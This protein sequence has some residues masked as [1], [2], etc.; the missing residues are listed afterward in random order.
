MSKMVPKVRS[1]N[2]KRGTR[3]GNYRILE[4]IG[5]GCEGEVYKVTEVTTGVI[6]A[7]KLF[8]SVELESVRQLLH[9]A[10]Y[11]DQLHHTGH[12]PNYYQYGQ[13]FLDGSVGCWFLIL[14]F[15]EGIPLSKKVQ[16][17]TND[18]KEK[19]FFRLAHAVADIHE[20]GY[21]IGDFSHLGNVIQA[22]GGHIFFHRLR[23]R[24]TWSSESRL[25]QRL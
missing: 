25:P 9:C 24:H 4:K 17:R 22:K 16:G 14:E 18:E 15:I 5:R 12:F 1:F 8:R 10:W 2:L 20:Y 11:Y 13:W 6:R 23:S 19:L 7:L 21:A 3:I